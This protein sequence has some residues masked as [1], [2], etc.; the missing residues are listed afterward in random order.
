MA[1]GGVAPACAATGA[2]WFPPIEWRRVES[3]WACDRCWVSTEFYPLLSSLEKL[4]KTLIA[5]RLSLRN[6]KVLQLVAPDLK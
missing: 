5:S 3:V 1:C 6:I 2:R 4:D